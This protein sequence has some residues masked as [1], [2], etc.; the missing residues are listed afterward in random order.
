MNSLDAFFRRNDSQSFFDM[1]TT[2]LR[3]ESPSPYGPAASHPSS[4][5][6]PADHDDQNHSLGSLGL[7]RSRSHPGYV[8]NVGGVSAK[9]VDCFTPSGPVMERTIA[10]DC[11]F[12]INHLILGMPDPMAE[13]IFG[14]GDSVDVDLDIKMNKQWWFKQCLI[15]LDNGNKT[16]QDS[17]RYVDIAITAQRIVQQCVAGTKD[18][19]GGSSHVGSASKDFYVILGGVAPMPGSTMPPRLTLPAHNVSDKP[20]S[21][22]DPK[23]QELDKRLESSLELFDSKN[24]V[25]PISCVKPGMPAAGGVLNIENCIDLAKTMLHD[26]NVLTYEFYTTEDTGGIRVPLIRRKATC[27]FQVNTHAE[28]SSSQQ[29]NLLRIVYYASEIMR[30]CALGGVAKLGGQGGFFVSVTGVDPSPMEVG[31][32]SLLN[33]TALNVT[34]Q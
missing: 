24:L 33:S 9:G 15:T 20:L 32:E 16:E 2:A 22:R 1:Q 17:F 25:V 8:S 7:D 6:N 31:L 5:G 34:V 29:F 3:L 23:R 4:R 19:L 30:I 18:A 13:L 21:S 28:Y 11:E 14:F 12:V 26:P 10:E 27:F